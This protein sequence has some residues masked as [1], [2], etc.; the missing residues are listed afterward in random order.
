MIFLTWRQF[1]DLPLLIGRKKMKMAFIKCV[2]STKYDNVIKRKP[3]AKFK[4]IWT[5]LEFL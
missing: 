4:M 3:R 1:C 2:S 5:E